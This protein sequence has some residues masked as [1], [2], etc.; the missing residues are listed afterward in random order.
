MLR[1]DQER[2][3]FGKLRLVRKCGQIGTIRT[4]RYERLEG[5]AAVERMGKA[6]EAVA[7]V[8]R[9]QG[10]DGLWEYLRLHQQ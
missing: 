8:K 5:F 4:I 1:D 7:Q 3:L 9:K 6:L 10:C 2:D